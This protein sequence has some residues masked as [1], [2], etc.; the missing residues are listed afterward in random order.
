MHIGNL[1]VLLNNWL[2]VLYFPQFCKPDM[3]MYG[4]LE[5]FLRVP[6]TSR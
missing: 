3:S 1:F 2:F 5:V 6:S 4:Y